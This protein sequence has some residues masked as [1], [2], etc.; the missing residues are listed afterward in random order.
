MF[1]YVIKLEEQNLSF[2]IKSCTKS[3][4]TD[5]HVSK[6][7]FDLLQLHMC[8]Q[9]KLTRIKWGSAKRLCLQA[10]IVAI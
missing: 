1:F 5:S 9:I 6:A 8:Q 3:C 2:P 10:Q 4:G 7:D